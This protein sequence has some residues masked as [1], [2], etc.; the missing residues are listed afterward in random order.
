MRFILLLLLIIF[1]VSCSNQEMVCN[2]VPHHYTLG[3]KCCP[4]ENNNFGCD[5]EEVNESFE[6]EFEWKL[7]K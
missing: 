3:S 2:D 6:F 1:L 4:D 5:N 7:V